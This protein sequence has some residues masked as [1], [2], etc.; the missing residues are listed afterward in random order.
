MYRLGH[1]STHHYLIGG[2]L[3][4]IVGILITGSLTISKTLL[5]ANTVLRQ[6]RPVVHT[7]LGNAATLQ[8]VSKSFFTL[9]IPASWHEVP[10]P[11]VTYTVYSWAG[12]T[13]ADAARRL[14]VYL[15]NVPLSYAV[16]RLQPIQA[17]GDHFDV[18]GTTS[19]NCISFTSRAPDSAQTGYAP[20]KWTGVNFLCD[21]IN[22]ERDV[23]A[24]G[25]PEGLNITTLTGGTSGSHRVLLIYTD[26]NPSPDYT[27]FTSIIKSFRLS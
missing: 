4:L 2:A 7:V 6:S 20:S 3:V 9:D 24:T 12:A 19:D 27:I 18:I 15:D 8:H 17:D 21:V 23:V 13:G 1:R 22:S 14:D 25:S 11:R 10:A 26:S 16:N 5:Q